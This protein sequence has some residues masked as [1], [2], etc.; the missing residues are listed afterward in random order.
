[1]KI[2]VLNAGSSSLKCKVFEFPAK[3]LL[4]SQEIEKIGESDSDIASHAEALEALDIDLRE[5]DI[6]GHRVVHGGEKLQQSVVIDESVIT[7]I[8]D[9]IPLAPLH[10]PA[11]LVGI[12]VARQKAPNIPQ[13]AVFDT[14]FHAT[15]PK[16]AYLY[17][18]PYELY[19][20]ED[21]R[22]Y[23]FHGTSHS[24]LAKEAAK[25]LKKE[26]RELNIITLHLGNG[27]SACAIKKGKSIDTSMGFTPLEG[28]VMGSRCGDLDPEIVLYLQ[29]ELG[30]TPQEVEH[31]LNKESGLLGICGENDLREIV[32]R[33]D[34][35]A[36]LAVAMMVRR[37]QKYIGAYMVLL[38]DV[39]AIVFSGGIGEHSQS[40]RE[41]V[42]DNKLFKNI[43][44]LVIQTDEELEIANESYRV[45]NQRSSSHKTQ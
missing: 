3:T 36:K 28:L 1:M 38:E 33:E 24:Y 26:L 43:K 16:E 37:I 40:V 7:T 29:R 2:A 6:I 11:N 41:M 9:L 35:R 30:K 8:K 22:R 39:D 31:I 32:L 34:E 21:I 42:M 5:I 27:A 20:K 23:G 19:E 15:L 44:M 4:F 45:I 12:E 17:A 18:L 10:N 25:E 13:V 14:A